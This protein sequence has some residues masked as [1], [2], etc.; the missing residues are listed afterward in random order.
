M[1]YNEID[2]FIGKFK[3]L[4]NAG[5]KA[6]LK[7]NTFNGE[8]NVAL[9][10]NLGAVNEKCLSSASTSSWSSSHKRGPSY[11]RRQLRRREVAG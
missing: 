8:L 10:A 2:S 7:L 11:E 3:F 1:D 9:E 6:W 5:I 4:V